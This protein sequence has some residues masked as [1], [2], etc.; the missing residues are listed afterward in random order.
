[1]GGQFTEE[2]S[3]KGVLKILAIGGVTL[4]L[5][6]AVL[7]QSDEQTEKAVEKYRQMLKQDP[8]SNP[9]LLDVD[10]GEELWKAPRGPN[11]VSLEKCDLGL[12]AGKV[13]GAYAQLPRYFADA[14]RV[15]D[16]E[17]RIMWCMEKL[18]GFAHDDLVK[19]PFPA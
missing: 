15:M 7:A 3:V 16:A 6:A 13:E 4:A 11:K 2:A 9:G 8:W 10:R 5:S 17:T 19:R 12:G 14:D 1:M 18:Q